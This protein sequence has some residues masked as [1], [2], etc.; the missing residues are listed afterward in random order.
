MSIMELMSWRL[1]ICPYRRLA[2]GNLPIPPG[3]WQKALPFPVGKGNALWG[4]CMLSQKKYMHDTLT[5]CMKHHVKVANVS[6]EQKSDRLLRYA[7]GAR[8]FPA[9][10]LNCTIASRR[11]EGRR[12]EDAKNLDPEFQVVSLSDFIIRDHFFLGCRTN[13]CPSPSL[14]SLL[15]EPFF[16]LLNVKPPP[17]Q[18]IS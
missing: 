18:R 5:W 17:C 14:N 3:T 13:F 1:V 12:Q 7:A 11:Q 8:W 9:C 4:E 2:I 16:C 15:Y 6:E 10:V